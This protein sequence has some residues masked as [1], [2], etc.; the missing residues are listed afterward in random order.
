MTTNDYFDFDN[1]IVNKPGPDQQNWYTIEQQS[2]TIN[3]EDFILEKFKEDFPK[4]RIKDFEQFK[5]VLSRSEKLQDWYSKTSL[6]YADSIQLPVAFKDEFEPDEYQG[7]FRDMQKYKETLAKESYDIQKLSEVF[8]KDL[9]KIKEKYRN[10]LEKIVNSNKLYPILTLKSIEM[11]LS[12]Q[13]EIENYTP[14]TG[15]VTNQ[16][17]LYAREM[18][19]S[20]QKAL[21]DLVKN[22]PEIDI[23]QVIE[24]NKVK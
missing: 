9:V 21:I 22:K 16:K 23:I 19:I 12:I 7:Y 11:P 20:Y 24:E 14:K 15:D 5:L 3:K 8:D 2:F 17:T 13:I 1:V 18:L 6:L 10:D 4:F